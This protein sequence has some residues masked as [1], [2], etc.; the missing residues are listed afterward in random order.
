MCYDPDMDHRKLL[1]IIGIFMGG[2][3]FKKLNSLITPNTTVEEVLKKSAEKKAKG[4]LDRQQFLTDMSDIESSGGKNTDHRTMEG[5]MHKG[6]HAVGQYGFMPKTI[7]E[8]MVRL[9][10]DDNIPSL[11]SAL[12]NTNLSEQ[13]LADIVGADP[14][15]EEAIAN[16]LYDVSKLN[17]VKDLGV[18]ATEDDINKAQSYRW[19]MGHNLKNVS[20]DKIEAHPRT[21]KYRNTRKMMAKK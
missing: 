5:G 17:T 15:S 19:E 16:K 7:S 18:N 6:Q 12:R 10:K 8:T 21:E 2:S 13:E 14:D 4:E 11:L 3:Q 20:E 1:L 9:K